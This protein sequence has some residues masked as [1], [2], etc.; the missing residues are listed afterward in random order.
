MLADR[1]RVV[2]MPGRYPVGILLV[3]HT[4]AVHGSHMSCDSQSCDNHS[5]PQ[6]II[7]LFALVGLQTSRSTQR[8]MFAP[9]K[10][11]VAGV[12]AK[13]KDISAM[14]GNSVSHSLTHL[15]L[16]GVMTPASA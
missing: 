11:T 13:L 14:T 2:G 16:R 5:P 7:P 3:I 1:A 12:F 9:P 6:T 10:L 8:V 4:P 15:I